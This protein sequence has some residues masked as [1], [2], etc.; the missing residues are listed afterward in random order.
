[1][2]PAFYT[3]SG[4]L[5]GMLITQVA[6]YFLEDKK[7]KNSLNIKQAELDNNRHHDLLKERR[8]AYSNYLEAIDKALTTEP[9]DLSKTVGPLYSA[10][11]VASDDT[12]NK[13]NTVFRI[14]KKKD[15]ETDD[16]ITAKKELLK[17]M[18]LEL[19]F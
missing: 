7:A 4:A 3:L 5:G 13:I 19:Q 12:T 9:K 8:T 6:N 16:F 10:L 18:Q 17:S 11:I 2:D 14:I 15:F 1:M